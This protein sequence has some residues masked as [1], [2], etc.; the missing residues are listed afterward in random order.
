MR[1]FGRSLLL[2]LLCSIAFGVGGVALGV[3]VAGGAARLLALALGRAGRTRFASILA[4][5]LPVGV[6]FEV[7]FL[8]LHAHTLQFRS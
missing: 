7:R 8:D 1:H 4:A 3:G 5:P 2:L 6:R